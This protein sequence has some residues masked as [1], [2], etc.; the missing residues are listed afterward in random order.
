M[1]SFLSHQA[2]DSPFPVELDCFHRSTF[3]VH[4]QPP[5]MTEQMPHEDLLEA[6]RAKVRALA[7]EILNERIP[8][9]DGTYEMH[10]LLAQSGLP[11]NDPSYR[12][13]VFIHSEVG[14][15]PIGPQR[16][17][18]APAALARLQPELDSAGAW[19]KPIA[20]GACQALL[21]RLGA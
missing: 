2:E 6:T 10:A 8:V 15:L 16:H 18:W 5:S 14:H 9:L 4:R 20:F 12:E 11:A 7:Q 3:I 13:F 17:L 19:A 21:V 1:G